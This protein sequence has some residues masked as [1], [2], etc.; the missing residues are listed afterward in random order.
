MGPEQSLFIT[1]NSREESPFM[2][3]IGVYLLLAACCLSCPLKTYIMKK[4]KL[5]PLNVTKVY[6][7]DSTKPCPAPVP[8]NG[9]QVKIRGFKKLTAE[10][11]H[12]IAVNGSSS[13][14]GVEN[15]GLSLK[16]S[17]SPPGQ[18]PG[19]GVKTQYDKE[20]SHSPFFTYQSSPSC[21]WRYLK[22]FYKEM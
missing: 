16:P 14:L 5:I 8:S 12:Y 7:Y 17:S 1:T 4:T 11:I 13:L 6:F 2:F 19:P 21:C 9:N 18:E 15:R 10:L 20:G 3:N 22:L